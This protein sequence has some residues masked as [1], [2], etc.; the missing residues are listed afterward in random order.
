MDTDRC[1]IDSTG[2]L[3]VR[4][5][6]VDHD[7]VRQHISDLRYSSG[8]SRRFGRLI[9][10]H[11]NGHLLT[12][13]GAQFKPLLQFIQSLELNLLNPQNTRIN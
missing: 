1:L 3:H 13:F 12:T 8:H 7:V 9:G 11:R 4:L 5:L 2:G 6:L 10:Y